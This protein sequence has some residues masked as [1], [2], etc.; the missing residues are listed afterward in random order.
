[1][2]NRVKTGVE[3]LD[4]VIEKGFPKGSLIL[5]AGE[6][7]TG[8]TVF[9]IQFLVKG[10]E[11]NEPGVYVSFAEAR[12][13]LIENFSRHLNVDLTK[14]EVEG[15]IKILDITAIKE[16]ALPIILVSILKEVEALKAERLVIDSFSAL[17]QAFKEP[18]DVRII[19]HTVLSRIVRG[20]GCT[21][22]MVEEVPIGESKIGF[23]IEEFVADSVIKF[24]RN[25]L[26]EHLFR[27]MEIIKLRGCRLKE[28]KLVYTLDKGFKVFPPFKLK[29]IEKPIRFQPIPDPPNKYSTGIKDLDEVLEGGIPRGGVMLLEVSEKISALEYHLLLDPIASQFVLKERSLIMVPSSGDDARVLRNVEKV[30]GVTEDEFNRFIRIIMPKGLTPPVTLPY[31]VSIEGK[32]WEE[33]LNKALNIAVELSAG[34]GKPNLF[35]IGADTLTTL[36]GEENCEKIL[37]LGATMARGSNSLI[38]AIVKAGYRNLAIK[39]SPIADVYIR[40]VRKHGCLLLYGVK[41]RTGLYA[42]EMDVSKGYPLPKLTPII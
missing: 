30:Y 27:D 5:L 15:K 28:H 37:N 38:V 21:T 20:I 24:R 36:Y 1:L 40:L 11:L 17:A 26:D 2:S 33:D 31:V 18:I 12:D 14:L 23:G 4:N 35:I 19:V 9:S 8:K 34:T 41:P 32:N 13:T 6:P 22:I 29:P 16:E 7:G 42:V 10:V 3:E 39:L 25:E